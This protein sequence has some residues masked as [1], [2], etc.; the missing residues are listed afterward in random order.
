MSELSL[1]K[2][3]FIPSHVPPH[4][5]SDD[6]L[7]VEDRVSMLKLAVKGEERFEISLYEAEKESPAYTVETVE[8]FRDHYG[9]DVEFFFITG[10]DWA[11]D[12]STWKGI[13]RILREVKFVMA[14]RPHGN[15]E[16]SIFQDRIINISIPQ[17]DISSTDIRRRVREK[18]PFSFMLPS[19][20]SSFIK[21]NCLYKA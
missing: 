2:I 13:D 3:I 16:D 14:D 4:K 21:R 7:P 6:I 9:K 12:L 18:R 17:I 1:E 20:V 19:E 10:S 11:G 5:T 15:Y 8:Y